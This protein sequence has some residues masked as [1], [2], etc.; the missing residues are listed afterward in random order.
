MLIE[1]CFFPVCDRHIRRHG[2]DNCGQIGAV[3]LI[4]HPPNGSWSQSAI[5]SGQNGRSA[6][7]AP[8]NASGSEHQ[9][10]AN[11]GQTFACDLRNVEMG[12]REASAD[13]NAGIQPG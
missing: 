13:R 5:G 3:A 1:V 6:S 7:L 10:T 9:F 12:Q 4:L 8:F 2:D 11:C